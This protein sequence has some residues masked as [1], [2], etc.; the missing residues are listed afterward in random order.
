MSAPKNRTAAEIE[1]YETLSPLVESMHEDI[2]ELTR[3]NQNTPLSTPKIQ[4]IN[5]LLT[6]VR[7]FLKDEPTASLLDLL[8][9]PL[10]PQNA[11]AL[12]ALGQYK[13][14]LDRYFEKYTD[15]DSFGDARTW[16]PALANRLCAAQSLW[17]A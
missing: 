10:I 16:K 7:A 9:E 1:T 13:A 3:K 15:Q 2:R 12:L 17:V 6:Q 14:A 5:R 8:D 11:D 4:M